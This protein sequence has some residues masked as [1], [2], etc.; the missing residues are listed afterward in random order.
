MHWEDLMNRRTTLMLA[1]MVIAASPALAADVT[2]ERLINADR[3]PHNWL[4]L[5]L[6]ASR[7]S[8]RSTRAT[9]RT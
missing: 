1:G 4:M 9:S 2:P 3:E 8:T 7:R 6:S 5:T